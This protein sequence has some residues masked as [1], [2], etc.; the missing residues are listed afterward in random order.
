MR[1]QY[2]YA[3]D[4]LLDGYDEYGILGLL[5][6]LGI[7][8]SGVRALYRLMIRTDYAKE[9]KLAFLC[10]NCAVWLVFYVEPILP[11]MQWLFACYALMNGIMDAMNLTHSRAMH[12]NGVINESAT[13]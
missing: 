5:M 3:H 10:V 8:A 9:T 2:G 6:L 1:S 4:L 12:N 13:N 11:G 7:L